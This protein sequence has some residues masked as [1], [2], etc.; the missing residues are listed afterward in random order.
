MIPSLEDMSLLMNLET[1]DVKPNPKKHGGHNA[2]FAEEFERELPV[3][4]RWKP[5]PSEGAF[6]SP[7]AAITGEQAKQTVLHYITA[8]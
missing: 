6:L 5:Q 1:D 3:A 2:P 4:D 7:D 8:G